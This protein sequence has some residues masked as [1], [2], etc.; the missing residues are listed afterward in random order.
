M[1]SQLSWE[2]Q[3]RTEHFFFHVSGEKTRGGWCVTALRLITSTT[4]PPTLCFSCHLTSGFR[5]STSLRLTEVLLSH[6]ST[7]SLCGSSVALYTHWTRT[8]VREHQPGLTSSVCNDSLY[9]WM[10]LKRV[11]AGLLSV[12]K[13]CQ[14]GFFLFPSREEKHLLLLCFTSRILNVF[15][16]FK[17]HRIIFFPPHVTGLQMAEQLPQRMNVTHIPVL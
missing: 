3:Q 15:F 11:S 6:I 17:M 16:F 4:S 12:F 13:P 9:L 1:L 2:Q 8:D 10:C 7:Q 14:S 5:P